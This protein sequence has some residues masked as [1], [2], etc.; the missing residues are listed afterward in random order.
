MF[1]QIQHGHI[2]HPGTSTI[3]MFIGYCLR[4]C[5]VL[6]R[7]EQSVDKRLFHMSVFP[8]LPPS[9]E[10]FGARNMAKVQFNYELLIIYYELFHEICCKTQIHVQFTYS[11]K[12]EERN[13]SP[14]S[15]Q[16]VKEL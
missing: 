12:S 3:A 2:T 4:V 1:V 13:S 15:P 16:R 9:R 11:T 7:Q 10:G 14:Q 8:T 5:E 6:K